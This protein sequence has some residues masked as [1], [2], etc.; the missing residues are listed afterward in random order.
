ME[1]ASTE[2]AGINSGLEKVANILQ[3]SMWLSPFKQRL[4]VLGIGNN[5]FCCTPHRIDVSHILL[6]RNGANQTKA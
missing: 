1:K 2:F 5:L 3:S 4:V 6:F